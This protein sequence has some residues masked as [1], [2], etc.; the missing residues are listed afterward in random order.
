MAEYEA[1]IID[2]T[3]KLPK[4]IIDVT[5][6]ASVADARTAAIAAAGSDY[7]ASPADQICIRPLSDVWAQYRNI[8]TEAGI[9][10]TT[11]A[12]AGADSN[13]SAIAQLRQLTYLMDLLNTGPINTE[14]PTAAALS[15]S[16][17][18][19]TCPQVGAAREQYNES[20]WER[21]RG[22]T[23]LTVFSSSARTATSNSSDQTNYNHRGALIYINVTSITSSPS[24]VFT[25]TGKDPIGVTNYNTILTSAAITGTG[26]TVL[27]IYPGVTVSANVA[28]SDVLPRTWR[29][30]ATHGNADS[31]TFSVAAYMIL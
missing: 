29:V 14:L 31:I 9:G 18:N 22:N 24:V 23:T 6:V 10:A 17:A 4:L 11:D 25:V 15:D 5:G 30:T 16:T 26:L 20:T 3:T 28:V 7:V 8:A 2:A 12:K 19:S 13:G 1:T 21:T 27:K